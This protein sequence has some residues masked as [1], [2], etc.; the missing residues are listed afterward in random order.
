MGLK[1]GPLG[2]RETIPYLPARAAQN[3]APLLALVSAEARQGAGQAKWLRGTG[4][5]LQGATERGQVAFV[6]RW[7]MALVRRAMR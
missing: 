3:P 1:L 2:P 4:P 7:I 6:I 5:I